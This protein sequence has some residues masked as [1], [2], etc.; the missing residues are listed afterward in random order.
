MVDLADLE[1]PT[2]DK[3]ERIMLLA[4]Q[5]TDNRQLRRIIRKTKPELRL[6]VYRLIVPFLSFDAKPYSLLKLK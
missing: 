1:V 4:A 6:D 2:R 5:I 3:M